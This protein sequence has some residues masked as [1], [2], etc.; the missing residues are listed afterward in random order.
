MSAE[1]VISRASSIVVIE[2]EDPAMMPTRVTAMLARACDRLDGAPVVFVL[3]PLNPRIL[4]FETPLSAR[5]LSML[6]L[7]RRKNRA[8]AQ[9][10]E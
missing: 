10:F 9:R 2:D 6:R 7:A 5:E 3:D 4:T 1:L 8:V